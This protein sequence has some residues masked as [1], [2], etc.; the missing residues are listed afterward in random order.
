MRGNESLAPPGLRHTATYYAVQTK[1]PLTRIPARPLQAY[2]TP[3]P[4][5]PFLGRTFTKQRSH[6]RSP[7]ASTCAWNLGTAPVAVEY[8]QPHPA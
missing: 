5:K 2:A 8:S 1:D 4:P 3:A 7:R 6:L